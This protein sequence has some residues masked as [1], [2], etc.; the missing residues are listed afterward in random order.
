MR[1][2]SRIRV[3]CMMVNN[4]FARSQQSRGKVFEPL[5]SQMSRA[6]FP[7]KPTI[8]LPLLHYTVICNSA[9]WI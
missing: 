6:I 2:S 3:E 4:A 1:K 7:L 9:N 8:M 5:L